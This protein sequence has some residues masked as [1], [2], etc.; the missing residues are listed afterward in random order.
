[1]KKALFLFLLFL[2]YQILAQKEEPVINTDRPG[3]SDAAR[4][5]PKGYFQMENG[6][7]FQTETVSEFG[8][9]Q[10]INFNSSLLKYGIT[11]GL[12]LRLNQSILAERLFENNQP[13]ELGWQNG[14]A[15]LVVGIKVNL[16]EEDGILPEMALVSEYTFAKSAGYFKNN[17]GAF[18]FNLI[19]LHHLTNDWILTYNVGVN[20]DL[21][22]AINTLTYTLKT[23]Y[24]V[25]K[26]SPYFEIYGS[27]SR[28]TT[29]LNYMNGGF[30]YLFSNLF[31]VDLHAGLDIVQL[32]NDNII[33]DQSFISLGLSYML[34]VKK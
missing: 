2:P 18:R 3:F 23:A 11:D 34:Q 4:T 29:P 14:L 6:F 22:S 32:Y 1:M 25:N 8:K 28:L 31:Q 12:E 15:P 7:L 20:R 27:R 30:S 33:Y 17:E 24:S 5:V 16:F 13:T 9:R 26:V 10:Y 19:S 21:G